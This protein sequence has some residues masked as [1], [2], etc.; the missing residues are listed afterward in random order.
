MGQLCSISSFQHNGAY[1]RVGGLC[2][3]IVDAI[4]IVR[5]VGR[6]D[7]EA[8]RRRAFEPFSRPQRRRHHVQVARGR[9]S[10]FADRLWSYHQHTNYRSPQNHAQYPQFHMSCIPLNCSRPILVRRPIAEQGSAGALE[11]RLS[12]ST[13]TTRKRTFGGDW[14]PSSQVRHRSLVDLLPSHAIDSCC[15]RAWQESSHDHS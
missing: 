6:A 3:G 9:G 13:T 11:T 8:Y 4:G 12:P 15:V 14:R 5:P 2:H 7:G 1:R 10:D